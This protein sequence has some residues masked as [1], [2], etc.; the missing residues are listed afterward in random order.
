[1]PF[2]QVSRRM[3]E[4]RAARRQ[5]RQQF[6]VQGLSARFERAQ[7]QTR[8][9]FQAEQQGILQDFQRQMA[10]YGEQMQTYEQQ[11]QQY[12]EAVQSYNQAVER[13]NTMNRLDGVRFI[14]QRI[15]GR[16]ATYLSIDPAFDRNDPNFNRYLTTTASGQALLGIP[17]VVTNV[18]AVD[19]Q[20]RIQGFDAA[21]LPDQF[22]LKDVGRSPGGNPM[23]E[24]Y[25]R[26]GPDPGEFTATMPTAPTAPTAQST[27][28]LAARF[29]ESLEREREMFEREIGQR[30]AATMTARRRIGAR[31]LL[32]GA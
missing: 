7:Q 9:A 10:T 23:F 27:E 25:Q 12:Q 21:Q 2:I 14:G 19:Q 13:Y 1:M 6:E 3:A 30:R 8:A 5:T 26:G 15:Q 11:A 29:T 28:G 16:P 24:L 32:S 22:A 20:A 17:G 18:W 4:R 31:P